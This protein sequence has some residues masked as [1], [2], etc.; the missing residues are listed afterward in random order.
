[1]A[2]AVQSVVCMWCLHV[3]GRGGRARSEVNIE[4]V[5]GGGHGQNC[6]FRLAAFKTSNKVGVTREN[7]GYIKSP[8][9]WALQKPHSANQ[10]L[11]MHTLSPSPN[12]C[13]LLLSDITLYRT[14]VE[15]A[16]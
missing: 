7:K 6:V 3:V 8:Q 12:G 1:M 15:S 13:L 11:A 14:F 9:C 10:T 2:V 4:D 16:N 5:L